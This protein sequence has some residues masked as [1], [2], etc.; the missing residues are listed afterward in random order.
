MSNQLDNFFKNKLLDRS[1]DYDDNVWEEARL[2]IEESEKDKKRRK[3]FVIFSSALIIFMVGATAYYL[4][5]ESV[6]PV[7]LPDASAIIADKN[8]TNNTSSTSTIT[9]SHKKA[10]KVKTSESESKVIGSVESNEEVIISDLSNRNKKT[11]TKKK[12][13]PHKLNTKD[14]TYQ[15]ALGAAGIEQMSDMP[16]TTTYNPHI[17]A[18]AAQKQV[19]LSRIES[20]NS[21]DRL[22]AISLL[23]NPIANLDFVTS[24]DVLDKLPAI[25]YTPENPTSDTHSSKLVFGLRAGAAIFP[26]TFTNF[27]GGAFVQY[28]FNRNI[29]LSIQPHYNYQELSQQTTEETVVINGFGLRTS[30]FS[31]SPESIRS[32]HVPV[33]LAYSFGAKNLDLSEVST[34]RFMK[35]KISTGISY[36]YLDGIT[37]SI[38]EKETSTS[39]SNIESGWLASSSFNRH[40]AEVIFGYEYFISKRLSL[41][42]MLRYR[43]RNQFSDVFLQLNPTVEQ[44]NALYIGLQAYYRLN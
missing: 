18:A 17:D 19:D 12:T 5:R 4:G 35:H 38:L 22:T 44:P 13:N 21:N 24:N 6:E 42:T 26:S 11:S 1:F 23:S 34:K 33:L 40:N 25:M 29:S 16:I 36:V 30:A 9:A 8:P 7:T 39:S 20:T 2:L 43:I 14:E 10:L 37:G 15:F 41:G 27:D 28:D 32:I 31:L 3:W